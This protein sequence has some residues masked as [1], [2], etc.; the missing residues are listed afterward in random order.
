MWPTPPTAASC[1][2]TPPG[3]PRR[4]ARSTDNGREVCKCLAAPACPQCGKPMT[5]RT[6][7]SGRN[8]GKEFWSCTGYPECKGAR[9][10][11]WTES[12]ESS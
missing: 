7:R 1:A 10:M 11:G 2:W 8:A 4:P 6:A 9:D 3:P 5:R 12:K